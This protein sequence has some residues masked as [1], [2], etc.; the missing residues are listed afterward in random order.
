MYVCVCVC[1]CVRA[2]VFGH[3][4]HTPLQ[5]LQIRNICWHKL[6]DF[7]L[8]HIEHMHKLYLHAHIRMGAG[9]MLAL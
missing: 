2:C 5:I 3:T 7:M 9:K 4:A 8:C 1:V 6:A